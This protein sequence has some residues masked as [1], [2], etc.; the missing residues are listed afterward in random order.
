MEATTVRERSPRTRSLITGGDPTS[1]LPNGR[2][3]DWNS[4]YARILS[5]GTYV[6]LSGLPGYRDEFMGA[7]FLPHTTPDLLRMR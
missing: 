3:S 5:I 4:A 2:G 6:D 7:S 1:S